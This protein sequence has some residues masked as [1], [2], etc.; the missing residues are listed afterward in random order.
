MPRRQKK[1]E[2]RTGNTQNSGSIEGFAGGTVE[3]TGLVRRPPEGFPSAQPGR[4]PPIPPAVDLEA[5]AETLKETPVTTN[6]SSTGFNPFEQ[7]KET[8]AYVD[9][10][11]AAI[12]YGEETKIFSPFDVLDAAKVMQNRALDRVETKSLDSP[13]TSA[14]RSPTCSPKPRAR[15]TNGTRRSG[16]P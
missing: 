2:T 14:P 15:R 5:A 11:P 3:F 16:V 7:K 4:E 9:E 10:G 13:E 1:E 8:P 12:L 6:V